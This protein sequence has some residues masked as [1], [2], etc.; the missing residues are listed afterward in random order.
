MSYDNAENAASRQAAR[1]FGFAFEGVFYQHLIVKGANRDSAW[2]S[3]LDGEWPALRGAFEA[4]LDPGNF[5][6]D[7]RQRQS[8]SAFRA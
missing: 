1:R 5:D 7:G 8:L 3:I 2:F 4:W 6:A